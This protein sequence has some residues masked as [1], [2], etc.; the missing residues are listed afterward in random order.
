MTKTKTT[1]AGGGLLHP[2]RPRL[3]DRRD[4]GH[5]V[6]VAQGPRLGHVRADLRR[7]H[8]LVVVHRVLEASILLDRRQLVAELL[9][10]VE[11]RRV[12]LL[13]VLLLE[14]RR[15]LALVLFLV[16]SVLVHITSTQ[17]ISILFLVHR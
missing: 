6:R 4:V 3:R 7:G 16:R 12:L 2:Q 14:A 11:D 1:R 8:G 9:L 17:F 13:L 10:L 15:H 5:V